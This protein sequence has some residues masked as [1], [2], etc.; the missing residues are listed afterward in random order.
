VLDAVAT[1]CPLGNCDS[2][3]FECDWGTCPG[4]PLFFLPGSF[5]YLP[6]R[7]FQ[8]GNPFL[9]AGLFATTSCGI[10]C[11]Q[12]L[13]E[14]C[15]PCGFLLSPPNWLPFT[16]GSP[17]G[18]PWCQ[19]TVIKAGCAIRFLQPSLATLSLPVRLVTALHFSRSFDVFEKLSSRTKFP[20]SHL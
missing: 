4:L 16:S 18:L 13:R 6:L 15:P 9:S 14:C 20:S 17:F 3:G 5:S 2:P 10:C 7:V 11:A 8:A 12:T 1:V 19:T